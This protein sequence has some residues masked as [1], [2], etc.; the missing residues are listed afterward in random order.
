MIDLRYIA[1]KHLEAERDWMASGP[2]SSNRLDLLN[3]LDR[4]ERALDAAVELNARVAEAE[5][6]DEAV[7][8]SGTPSGNPACSE[9]SAHTRTCSPDGA[10]LSDPRVRPEP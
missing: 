5:A 6:A 1:A 2:D 7:R 3:R 10:G 4:W 8:E 9:S